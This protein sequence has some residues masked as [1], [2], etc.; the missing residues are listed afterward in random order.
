MLARFDIVL[1]AFPFT[2]GPNVKPRPAMVICLTER[3]QDVLLAFISSK[4]AEAA[5][6]DELDLPAE[7]PQF[8][9]SGL[10]VSS[11]CRLSRMTT[12][13]M[14]LVRRRIGSL[15][16]DLRPACVQILRQVVGDDA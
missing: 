9:Q 15:P 1:V 16:E 8:T 10:K 13:A 11:R 5:S 7:H 14:P 12:L 2:N 3:H 4:V 6:G